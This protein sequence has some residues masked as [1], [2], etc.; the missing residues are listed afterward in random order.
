MI[1][2]PSKRF[3]EGEL[4]E[5]H[6]GLEGWFTVQAVKNGA[7]VRSRS[8]KKEVGPFHNLITDL[9]LDRIGSQP[10]T[11]VYRYCI[12]GTGTTAP[13]VTDTQLANFH[14]V[15]TTS[16]A[17]WSVS[18]GTGPAPDYYSWMRNTWTSAIGALGTVNL[19]E[20]GVGGA[21]GNS[22]LFSREL[23]RDGGGSPVSFPLTSDEQLRV[24]YELRMYPPLGDTPAT[25][26]VGAT[27]HDTITR[28][29]NIN[30]T[31]LSW[32]FV[33]M[34]SGDAS[35]INF[36]ASN[37]SQQAWS[38]DL[39]A[40]TATNPGG[41]NLGTSTSV[42]TAGYTN[43]NHYRDFSGTWG[44]TVGNGN[45]RTLMMRNNSTK[46]QVQYDPVIVKNNTQQL[47]LNQRV[48]WARR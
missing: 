9:G 34:D 12:V 17:N 27:S 32:H 13:A 43:G 41:T 3:I 7:V 19:T 18:V 37:V 10:S 22:L 47:I 42:A 2:I 48:S 14:G 6:V 15:V 1:I 24:I 45:I 33:D 23:I 46:W 40:V 4:P 38:G 30:T 25:V 36:S 5:L 39:A 28:A 35:Q 26:L 8:F 16:S 44:T 21:N 31:S 11:A 29:L 20:V